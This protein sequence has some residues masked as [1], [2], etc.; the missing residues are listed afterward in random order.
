MLLYSAAAHPQLLFDSSWVVRHSNDAAN[1]ARILAEAIRLRSP[2]KVAAIYVQNEWGE[3]YNSKLIESL[4]LGAIIPFEAVGY[5]PSDSDFRDRLL[6][7]IGHRPD[8]FVVNSFGAAAGIII[9]QLR[10]LGFQGA[11]Y[12]NNGF[13]LS[14]DT[15]VTLGE[16]PIAE[17]YFQDY[18]ELPLE[19]C[20]LYFSRYRT[21][22]G[23]LALA[24]Y[25]DIELLAHASA[26]VG[27]SAEA[28]AKYIRSLKGFHGK[29]ESVDISAAG[30]ITVGTVVRKWDRSEY[31]NRMHPTC[32]AAVRQ[33]GDS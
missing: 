30:D 9:K 29:Y 20:E 2:K 7:L 18:P 6:P 25:T 26:Q 15:F 19:F 16:S 11:I 22:P 14:R 13:V 33:V 12:A 3:F 28:M 23:Y 4:N 17:L 31:T 21:K 8:I 10:Q 32:R 27:S 5:P 24:G 1:D